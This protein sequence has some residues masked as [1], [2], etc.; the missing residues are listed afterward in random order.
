MRDAAVPVTRVDGGCEGYFAALAEGAPEFIT[1]SM[2]PFA[3]HRLSRPVL[4][5]ALWP[6]VS[7]SLAHRANAVVH[8]WD[9]LVTWPDIATWLM[10]PSKE[11]C[12]LPT[13]V[14]SFDDPSQCLPLDA[15]IA[16][17]YPKQ[18]DPKMSAL[19]SYAKYKQAQWRR[20]GGGGHAA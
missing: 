3:F 7:K 11:A 8:P 17:W 5:E 18:H 2:Y 20:G 4:A 1:S 19:E 9:R 13:R 10:I 15:H 12:T 14:P 6:L 16:D